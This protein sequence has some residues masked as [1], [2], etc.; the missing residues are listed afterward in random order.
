MVIEILICVKYPGG[1][2]RI[3]VADLRSSGTAAA[4][5]TCTGISRTD[6]G[7]FTVQNPRPDSWSRFPSRNSWLG[8]Y[9]YEKRKYIMSLCKVNSS[10]SALLQALCTAHRTAVL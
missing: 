10:T 6:H 1:R 4:T 2:T 3:T 8:V 9:V 5:G 7:A